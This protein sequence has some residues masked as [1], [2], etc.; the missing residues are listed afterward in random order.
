MA[1]ITWSTTFP[2]AAASGQGTLHVCMIY[3]FAKPIYEG[4]EAQF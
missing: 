2:V 3:D 1:I 4:K